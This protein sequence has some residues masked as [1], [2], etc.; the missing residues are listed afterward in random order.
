MSVMNTG[1][2]SPRVGEWYVRWDNGELFQVTGY[3]P[4]RRASSIENFQGEMYEIGDESWSI[5]PLA[6]VRPPQGW[7]TDLQF[8]VKRRADSFAATVDE[9]EP[10]EEI[11]E[12]AARGRGEPEW[13]SRPGEPSV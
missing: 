6:T 5:L 10:T 1:V 4:E 7:T 2:G 12:V 13:A 3:H 9:V 8:S 11:E